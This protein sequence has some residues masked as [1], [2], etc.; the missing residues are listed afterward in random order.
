VLLNL[1]TQTNINLLQVL[2]LGFF[3]RVHLFRRE[4]LTEHLVEEEVNPG[5][6]VI[7]AM[8]AGLY[9]DGS[10]QHLSVAHELGLH[11]VAQLLVR[12]QCVE[13]WLFKQLEKHPKQR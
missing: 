1:L 13:A 4:T 6:Q 12:P 7:R 10:A 3:N 9:D 2:D 8:L 11:D 5:L